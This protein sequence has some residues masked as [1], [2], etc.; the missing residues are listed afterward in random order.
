MY[1]DIG[2]GLLIGLGIVFFSGEQDFLLILFGA[3][4][5]LAPDVDFILYLIKRRF[6]IDQYAHEHRDLLHMP[7]LF[8]I[9]GGV[10]IFTLISQLYA[11][12]WVLGTMWHFV[13][14]TLDG[15]WGIRWLHPFYSGYFTLATYSP[16]N[17]IPT[18]TEQREIATKHGNPNW[19]EQDYF[20][21]NKKLVTEVTVLLAAI[22]ATIY[23][24]LK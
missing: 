5:A 15:G 4:A 8:S 21:L 9:G 3:L 17:H 20:R 13:H 14:D 1:I 24:W 19:L 7:L 23:W 10:L 2:F 22:G 12:V 16:K 18:K 11:I 6:K